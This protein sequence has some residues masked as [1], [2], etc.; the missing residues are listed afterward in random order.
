MKNIKVIIGRTNRTTTSQGYTYN[1]TGITYNHDGVLYGGL[2]GHDII[3]MTGKS[4]DVK[5]TNMRTGDIDFP[6]I[7]AVPRTLGR[8]MLI[9]MMGMTYNEDIIVT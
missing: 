1:E 4:R 2:S 6:F 8:G 9:G 7:P 5:P 3:P